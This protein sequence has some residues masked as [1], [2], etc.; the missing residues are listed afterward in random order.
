MLA[1][2]VARRQ[3][4]ERTLVLRQL[5]EDWIHL[6]RAAAAKRPETVIW[7]LDRVQRAKS[8][9]HLTLAELLIASGAVW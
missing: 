8:M 7:R 2:N 3:R 4:V 1:T 9:H 6:H 5:R